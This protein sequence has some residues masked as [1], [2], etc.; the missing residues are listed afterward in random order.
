[1][2]S[3]GTKKET[4]VVESE[5]R[6][7]ERA[8]GKIVVSPSFE[9]KLDRVIPPN[10]TVKLDATQIQY[11]QNVTLD[12]DEMGWPHISVATLSPKNPVP[13]EASQI[14]F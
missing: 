5:A 2:I 9:L 14:V 11:S 6:K 13:I 12:F 3:L 7:E 10:T 8:A 1:V 4:R